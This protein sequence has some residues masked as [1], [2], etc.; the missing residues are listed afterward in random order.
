M[1]VALGWLRGRVWLAGLVTAL[2]VAGVVA[3]FAGLFWLAGFSAHG[4]VYR[5]DVAAQISL[6]AI[7]GRVFFAPQSQFGLDTV[8]SWIATAESIVGIVIE[9]LFVA[10][11]IQRLFSR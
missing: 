2:L 9:G 6:N 7:H 5:F 11:L 3:L 10:V 8:Q 1:Q 4:T